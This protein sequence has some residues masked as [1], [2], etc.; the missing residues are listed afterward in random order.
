MDQLY[1]DTFGGPPTHDML[2]EPVS[3]QS[4]TSSYCTSSDNFILCAKCQERRPG[5]RLCWFCRLRNRP[6]DDHESSGISKSALKSAV[7]GARVMHSS[8]SSS[9]KEYY[10]HIAIERNDS[11]A[12]SPF[13]PTS[14][15]EAEELVD[16]GEITDAFWSDCHTQDYYDIDARNNRYRPQSVNYDNNFWGSRGFDNSS[17]RCREVYDRISHG[18]VTGRSSC[19][20]RCYHIGNHS[21]HSSYG[22]YGDCVTEITAK[23][24]LGLIKAWLGSKVDWVKKIYNRMIATL[25]FGQQ[26]DD[27]LD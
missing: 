20:Y 14:E 17:R 13:M 11:V 25:Q 9:E 18:F 8:P 12:D 15:N 22:K 23:H 10:E 1:I 2:D 26:P 7:H 24:A 16:G 19:C 5:S 4:T 21:F 3:P 6:F 27:E